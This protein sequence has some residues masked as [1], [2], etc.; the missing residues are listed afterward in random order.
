MSKSG[1]IKVQIGEQSIGL[2]FGFDAIVMF[3]EA[4]AKKEKKYF[5]KVEVKE[6][7]EPKSMLTILGMAKL[8]HCAYLNN[9]EIKEVDPELTNEDFYNWV[10]ELNDTKEGRVVM[11][12]VVDVYVGSTS[13]KKLVE[14]AEAEE[15]QKKSEEV[16]LGTV[17]TSG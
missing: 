17:D 13:S 16:A 3:A 4:S 5:R 2:R 1:Y 15:S 6:G 7:E 9:C 10:E 11:R 8:F 14:A 12:S